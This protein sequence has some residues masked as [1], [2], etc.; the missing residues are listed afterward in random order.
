MRTFMRTKHLYDLVHIIY[1]GEVGTVNHVK[2]S[3]N[4][5]SDRSK[6]VLILLVI[7]VICVWF[8]IVLSVPCSLV[9]LLVKG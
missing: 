4:F 5:L 6:A 3:S 1:K 8:L 7:F 2:P 9:H